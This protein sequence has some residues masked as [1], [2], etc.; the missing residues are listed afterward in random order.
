MKETTYVAMI[1]SINVLFLLYGISTLSISYYEAQ[2]FYNESNFVHY[3]TRASC[4]VFGQNDYA[5]RLPFIFLHVL[6]T[7]LIYK[8][9]KP[10][11]KRKIDR[12][13]SVL[14]Y[15]LLP[16]TISAALLV[17]AAGVILFITL[18]FVFLY[19]ENKKIAAFVVLAISAII[20]QGFVILYFLLFFYAI[21]KRDNVLIA[22]S[23]VLFSISASIYGMD[24]KGKPKGYFLDTF[25]V[26]AAI[27][28]PIVFLYF[29]Y[30]QY[31]ILIKK[32]KNILW[33]I[34]FGAFI[35]SLLLSFRQR[36]P[37]EDFAP[38]AVIA[39]PL[40][41]RSFFN[42]YRVRL[43]QHRKIHKIFLITMFL[44]LFISS[45]LSIFNHAMYNLYEDPKKHFAYPYHV[46]KDLSIILHQKN[47]KFL[48][49]EDKRLALRLKFYGI[50]DSKDTKIVEDI[51]GDIKVRYL[52]TDI[53]SFKIVKL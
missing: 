41:I 1:I 31:R 21:A 18:L 44:S 35:C 16:G 37:I 22:L 50:G 46:A 27:F 4:F 49:V 26:Y 48:H 32:Q 28:S 12:V 30:V 38:F 11:L 42:S 19:Q 6:S 53:A 23:L 29:I 13:S 47:I 51:N 39:V 43:P 8:V 3:I 14:I 9:G 2:T 52:F 25:G 10:H 5:L 15:V 17:N 24:I 40:M 45:F 36:I 34:S 20:D 7:I 33:W